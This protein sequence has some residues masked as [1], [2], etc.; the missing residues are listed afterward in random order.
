MSPLEHYQL[1][2]TQQE[3]IA[4]PLQLAALKPLEALYQKLS[5]RHFYQQCILKISLLLHRA[6]PAKGVYL[7]GG[8]GIGKTFLMD[9]FY[10]SLSTP[11]KKRLHFNRFMQL[12]HQQL[13]VYQGYSDP[14]KKIARALAKEIHV[15]CFDEM[16]V[17][18]ITDAMILAEL[19]KW[20][21][22]Q[23]VIVVVTSNFSPDELYFNGLQRDKFLPFI[24]LLKKHTEVYHL[25]E[26]Q[27]YRLLFL[28]QAE[29]YQYPLN[30]QTEKKLERYFQRLA[31]DYV[32]AQTTLTIQSRQL[33]CKKA[34]AG[35]A[36]FSFEIL[37][38]TPRSVQDYIE[39]SQLFHTV[40][41]S[42]V[43]IMHATQEDVAKRFIWLI[44]EFYE[45]NVTLIMSGDVPLAELY[46]GERFK[47]EFQRTL[48]RLTEM[49]SAHYL[50][51]RHLS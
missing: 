31:L 22:A 41:L 5:R 38:N 40:L 39:L 11:Y 34:V 2:L 48:S 24:S 18:D 27:D 42:G 16:Y 3:I 43:F 32:A 50:A 47:F 21:F 10:Q 15:L 8:V 35:V 17:T 25:K 12:V 45:R 14:L 28:S 51:Q 9:L 4:D 23:G 26:V 37:C 30:S 1:K 6:T 44:D 49:Q 46:Q 19:F 13:S 20:L 29:I 33:P 36:W 7:W